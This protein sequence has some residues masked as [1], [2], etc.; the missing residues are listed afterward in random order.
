[1]IATS[2]A[3]KLGL[4]LLAALALGHL[5][6]VELLAVAGLWLLIV[7]RLIDDQTVG[8]IFVLKSKV[9]HYRDES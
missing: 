3:N 2:G 1:L 6:L 5:V 4:S 7:E 9:S 8:A